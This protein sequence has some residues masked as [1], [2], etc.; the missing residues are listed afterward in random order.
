VS[1]W[2]LLRP[3][4]LWLLIGL[5]LLFWA[6][7]RSATGWERHFAFSALLLSMAAWVLVAVAAAGPAVQQRVPD[8]AA[9]ILLDR[10]ASMNGAR[11]RRAIERARPFVQALDSEPVIVVQGATPV[12]VSSLPDALSVPR[13]APEVGTE[14]RAAVEQVLSQL[15]ARAGRRLLWVTDGAVSGPSL[16]RAFA[17]AAMADVQVFPLPVDDGPAWISIRG[18]QLS[19]D[20]REGEPGVAVAEV[21]SG[22]RFDQPFV[23][24]HDKP[25]EGWVSL[26][27]IRAPVDAQGASPQRV[28]LPYATPGAGLHRLRL[29]AEMKEDPLPWDNEIS[30]VLRV[31]A[32]PRVRLVGD[33][34]PSVEGALARATPRPSVQRHSGLSEEL[35]ASIEPEELLI[36]IDPSFEDLGERLSE[37]LGKAVRRGLRLWIT[38]GA[39]ELAV[40][41]EDEHPGKDLLPVVLPKKKKKEPAPMAVLFAIDRSDSMG[42]GRKFDLALSAVANTVGLLNPEAE[43]AVLT[44]NDFP[45]LSRPLGRVEDPAAFAKGLSRLRVSGGTSMYP[46]L[47]LALQTLR[48]SDARIKH[49][50]VAT[51]GR[52]TTTFERAGGVVTAL[53]RNQVTVSAVGLGDDADRAEME[54]VAEAGGGNSYFVLNLDDLPRILLEETLEVVR[55]NQ[56]ERTTPVVAVAG[57]RFLEGIDL[58]S[59]P[60]IHGFVR[61]RQKPSSELA[62]ASDEGEPILVSWRFGRGTVT[63]LTTEIDGAWTRDWASWPQAPVFFRR[64]VDE[65]LRPPPPPNLRLEHEPM[66]GAV[67]LRFTVLDGLENPRSGLR[68]ELSLEGPGRAAERFP[69]TAVAPGRYEAKLPLDGARLAVARALGERPD[70]PTGGSGPVPGGES[71]LSVAPAAP[72]EARLGT[73]NEAA[74]RMVA[75]RTGG[76]LDPEPEDFARGELPKRIEIHERSGQVLWWALGAWCG[77]LIFRRMGRFLP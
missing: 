48:E 54:K 12:Q 34:A 16:E 76:Q 73:R 39:N 14:I 61:S 65:T 70:A 51:D 38:S 17:T 24:E 28:E 13:A 23:L 64:L 57:S 58:G 36:L 72:L 50:I 2:T 20:R 44:Y 77:A 27:E 5:P 67:L 56:V 21:L 68:T 31:A 6:R 55:K 75:D 52:S 37:A 74:L 10:S 69:L 42:R 60:A 59:I 18:L 46:A 47:E 41:D 1:D 3:D 62:L 26:A 71:V 11:W 29:V 32:P 45:E 30:A 49:V 4:W 7:P 63:L 15:K 19:Q 53:R 8:L 9:A 33:G 40:P 22:G 35:L 25:G 66:E 43:V